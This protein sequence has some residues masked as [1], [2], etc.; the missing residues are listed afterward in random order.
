VLPGTSG[1]VSPTL[2]RVAD[3]AD[4]LARDHKLVAR[5]AR[6]M[7]R[8]RDRGWTWSRILD[9]EKRPGLL[10]LLRQV[11]KRTADLVGTTAIT[12]AKSLTREGESRR[13][14]AKRLGVT[15]QRVSALLNGRRRTSG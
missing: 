11:S 12:F 5:R 9:S 15:H 7:Q 3:A 1:D 6:T 14:I 13:Q 10:E 2:D 8:Q 4:D